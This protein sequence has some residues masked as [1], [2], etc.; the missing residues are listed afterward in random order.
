MICCRGFNAKALVAMITWVVVISG[1]SGRVDVVVPC[2]V[3]SVFGQNYP[4]SIGTHF[5]VL[6]CTD[7]QGTQLV[8]WTDRSD[9]AASLSI[10]IQDSRGIAVQLSS[11]VDII[12]LRVTFHNVTVDASEVQTSLG[13]V[14]TSPSAACLPLL[15]IL[16]CNNVINTTVD[17]RDVSYVRNATM[18]KITRIAR[19]VSRI[20]VT[21]TQ[22]VANSTNPVVSFTAIAGG[23]SDSNITVNGGDFTAFA[24]SATEPFGVVLVTSSMDTSFIILN[25]ITM[26]GGTVDAP[27]KANVLSLQSMSCVEKSRLCDELCA[28][29]ATLGSGC[30]VF[31]E[32]QRETFFS[33]QHTDSFHFSPLGI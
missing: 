4:F 1:A 22:V 3:K 16:D 30:T 9:V 27:D 14:C 20:A 17:V 33:F 2:G 12:N 24:R 21:L 25:D 11:S 18:I 28:F 8:V 19:V 15:Q 10:T 26:G 29:A 23:V 7:P 6:N 31:L 13:V 5:L 32:D